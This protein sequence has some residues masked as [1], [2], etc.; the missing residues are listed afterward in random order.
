MRFVC[1]SRLSQASAE[2]DRLDPTEKSSRLD[3]LRQG[4]SMIV[5]FLAISCRRS[6]SLRSRQQLN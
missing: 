6:L 2:E 3:S 4:V 1:L 5:S